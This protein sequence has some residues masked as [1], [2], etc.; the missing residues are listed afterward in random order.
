MK[1]IFKIARIEIKQLFYSP[2]AW[3][4][5]I[6]FLV[7]CGFTYTEVLDNFVRRQEM[8]GTA[9]TSMK[10]L[11]AW[12]FSG[13]Q[14]MFGSVL[15]NIFLYVPLLTMGLISREMSSGTIKLLYTSPVTVTQIVLGKYV[16]ML[17][18][19]ACLVACIGFLM[20]VACFN[21]QSPDI[22]LL[23][24]G[25][26]GVFL[27]LSTY[28]AIGVFMS[29]LT[30]YQILAGIG[31]FVMIGILSYV[32]NVWQRY[33]FVRDLTYFLSLTGRTEKLLAGL[34][35]SKDVIYFG[36]IIFIFLSFTILRMT[37][38]RKSRTVGQSALRYG[39]VL[40]LALLIGYVSSRPGLIAYYDVTDIES[41]SLAPEVKQ[42][43]K[44]LGDEP[45]E[46]TAYSNLLGT[47]YELGLPEFRNR[48]LDFWEPY[49]RYKPN[50]SFKYVSYFDSSYDNTGQIMAAPLPGG[51]MPSLRQQ[52]E[53]RAKN[54]DYTIADYQSPEKMRE[55]IDLR[56][57]LTRFVMQ[58]KYKNRSTFLRV[59][60]DFT[61][62]PNEPE[63]AAALKRLQNARFPK[64][65][66]LTGDMERSLFRTGARE[67][68]Y[69][70]NNKPFRYAFV[71][72]GFDVDTVSIDQADIPATADVVVVA[73]PLRALSP[74]AL[75]KIKAYV[76]GGGNLLVTA[77]SG[78][79]D[80]INPVISPLGVQLMEGS[81]AEPDPLRAANRVLAQMTPE[82]AKF[83]KDLAVKIRNKAG[84]LM[85]GVTGLWFT[86]DSGYS[87][88]TLLTNDPER[89]FLKKG[90][91][92]ADTGEV[93][94]NEPK[95]DQRGVFPLAL[96]LTRQINGK[97]QRIVVAGDADFLSNDVSTFYLP[98][99]VNFTF[100]TGLFSWLTNRGFPI[101]A[102][103]PESKDRRLNISSDG[104]KVLK[105]V[106]I[107]IVPGMV[108]L[109]ASVLLIR[110]KR[111]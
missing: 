81:I 24:S 88:K 41:Q 99:A 54:F 50:I 19:N 65:V 36:A 110:R 61:V 14:G 84:V 109:I 75:Q 90:A 80:I 44:D 38:T 102:D 59:F 31:T 17:I 73:D 53:Q 20:I 106:L 95:G 58:I 22:P 26:L 42:I 49:Q 87:V 15:K 76:A 98:E 23:L 55:T 82:T 100:N 97:Q 32:G 79:Q 7:Q 8:G 68:Q 96:A 107:W 11:T 57:E 91:L 89:S 43:V 47:Y 85:P 70:A 46:V 3:F 29:S 72:Q 5:L 56:P 6:V 74:L 69:L 13:A 64:I 108:L 2:I 18:Y 1:M 78:R 66:F 21:I 25:L 30:T 51:G 105:I 27:L 92:V 33:D 104:V 10:T 86:A 48:Y 34:I 52:A 83:S 28:A 4:L 16:S 111:K 67:Y 94:F 77:E 39:G 12:M 63:V 93:V 103:L 45:M 101:G 40:V 37:A 71:N 60:N 9:M 35:S 62:F